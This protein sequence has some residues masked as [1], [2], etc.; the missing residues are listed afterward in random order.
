MVGS[1]FKSGWIDCPMEWNQ[2]ELA[3]QFNALRSLRS[4]VYKA[5][6]TARE[7]GSLGSFIEAQVGVATNSEQ[8]YG[9]MNRFNELSRWEGETKDYNLSDIFIVPRTSVQLVGDMSDG[10]MGSELG[11]GVKMYSEEGE[12]EW[13]GERCP[14][15][16]TVWRAEA[17]GM[18]KCP[19]CW[20]WSS[21]CENH[22]CLR[23][24]QVETN[25][26]STY[27]V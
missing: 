12:V 1:V 9:L 21:D 19:R 16:V 4:V 22:L 25:N 27:C 11:E 6:T 5:L 17:V 23:C 7:A 26:D 13:G 20:L 14:V 24:K 2:P 15:R 8:L 3:A 18:H 10:I